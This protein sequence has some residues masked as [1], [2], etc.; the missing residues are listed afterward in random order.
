LLQKTLY[1]GCN[2]VAKLSFTKKPDLDFCGPVDTVSNDR[3][4][5]AQK[6]PNRQGSAY[7]G[8]FDG[9]AHSHYKFIPF[10]GELTITGETGKFD[11]AQGSASFT[12]V[13]TCNNGTAF[14]AVEGTVTTRPPPVIALGSLPNSAMRVVTPRP[15]ADPSFAEFLEE[16]VLGGGDVGLEE[17]TPGKAF[18]YRNGSCSWSS[19]GW[20]TFI[21][22]GTASTA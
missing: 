19:R 16:T 10:S 3:C 11:G 6:S 9:G 18:F 2:H 8:K 7:Q 22:R 12:A 13:A 20:R 21:T 17:K 1:G 5:R 14:Y 4:S 15:I